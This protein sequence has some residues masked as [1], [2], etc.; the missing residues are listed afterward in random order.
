MPLTDAQILILRCCRSKVNKL[1]EPSNDQSRDLAN[2]ASFSL[3]RQSH[4]PTVPANVE[5]TAEEWR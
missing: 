5:R 2:A 1:A 4:V 3:A